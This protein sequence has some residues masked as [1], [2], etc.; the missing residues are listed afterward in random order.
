PDG[1]AHVQLCRGRVKVRVLPDD[2]VPFLET[3]EAQRIQPV[4]P[5]LQIPARLEQRVPECEAL[6][7]RMMQFIPKLPQE[8]E[9]DRPALHTRHGD[10]AVAQ[11]RK[12]RIVD[13]IGGEM[14][15][16]LARTWAGYIDRSPG[17]GEIDDVHLVMPRLRPILQRRLRRRRARRR[18]RDIPAAP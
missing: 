9:P 14:L 8:A 15:E 7:A 18:E 6:I 11:V 3:K 2:D 1:P 12:Y 4:R 17:R 16:K 5:D 13:G 10:V